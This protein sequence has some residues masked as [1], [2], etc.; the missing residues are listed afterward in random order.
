MDLRSTAQFTA[1][2]TAWSSVGAFATFI[3]NPSVCDA[4]GE[5]T[6]AYLPLFLR[7]A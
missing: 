1:S 5:S 7:R 3:E 2:R 6:N 4:R